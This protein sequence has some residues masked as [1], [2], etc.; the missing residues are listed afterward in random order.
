[1]LNS[2]IL[3]NFKKNNNMIIKKSNLLDSDIK[4]YDSRSVI[5]SI[6]D[7]IKNMSKTDI[8]E[9]I[10]TSAIESNVKTVEIYSKINK[11]DVEKNIQLFKSAFLDI[12]NNDDI[13]K[14]DK[15]LHIIEYLNMLYHLIDLSNTSK[16]ISNVAIAVVS[17]DLINYTVEEVSS[18]DPNQMALLLNLK[19][20]FFIKLNSLF[21]LNLELK[22]KLIKNTCIHLVLN[23]IMEYSDYDD[24]YKIFHLLFDTALF[25]N[26]KNQ[27]Q[28]KDIVIK[29]GYD[30]N[31]NTFNAAVLFAN[32]NIDGLNKFITDNNF[33][34]DIIL[35]TDM[36]FYL[37]NYSLIE[38]KL[39]EELDLGKIEDN[40]YNVYSILKDLYTTIMPNYNK[41]F[42]ITKKLMI[43]HETD[44]EN[45]ME[46]LINDAV[47]Y[48]KKINVFEKEKDNIYKCAKEKCSVAVYCHILLDEK[49][50]D[51]LANVSSE[52]TDYQDIMIFL[53]FMKYN[54]QS[55]PNYDK[56]LDIIKNNKNADDEEI[57]RI[58][59]MS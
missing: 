4:E 50:Y 42:N 53:L 18:S 52:L 48:A 40:L 33:G 56:L 28:I 23:Y 46:N 9:F 59:N 36:L 21:M 17:M 6:Y 10:M 8:I 35:I 39:N 41:L 51:L 25:S 43:S 7:N 57:N 16:I 49:E 54:K 29:L 44:D 58:L 24:S 37:E 27:Q 13:E 22:D 34:E 47:M 14:R 12:A 20:Q 15:F 11:F 3:N 32:K 45:F 38:K 2:D 30:D 55:L 1:M 26:E 19:Q 5:D 31:L